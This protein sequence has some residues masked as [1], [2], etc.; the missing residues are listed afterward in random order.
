MA[1]RERGRSSTAS[2]P[3]AAPLI[4]R[5]ATYSAAPVL[6]SNAIPASLWRWLAPAFRVWLRASTNWPFTARRSSVFTTSSMTD[7]APSTPSSAKARAPA[8][9]TDRMA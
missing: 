3:R 8:G 9:K 6:M 1:L 2:R 4:Q 5:L 7:S